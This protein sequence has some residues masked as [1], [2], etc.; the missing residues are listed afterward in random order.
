MKRT[1]VLAVAVA[2]CCTLVY[3]ATVHTKR[4][5]NYI[6]EGPGAYYELIAIV[7]EN[8]PLEVV[9]KSDQW[10]QV[11]VPDRK[12][13]WIA[14]NCLSEK[15]IAGAK[16]V[17]LENVWSSPKA[18]RAGVSAAIKGFGEKY[19]KSSAGVLDQV[20]NMERKSF[21]AADVAAFAQALQREPSANRGRL[22]LDKL[23]L[24]FGG[25]DP[26]LSEQKIGAG[27]AARI[28]S[29]GLVD[30]RKLLDY[31][32]L[33]AASIISS[34][35][36][37]DWDVTIYILNDP[38]INGFAVPGGYI[39]ITLGAIQHCGDEAELAAIIA[40]E[41]GHIIARHGLTE[42]TS[43]M[44]NIL[45]DEAFAE[46]EEETGP[47]TP[48]EEELDDLIDK[49]YESIVAR[50][51][52][53]YEVAADKMSSVFCANAGYDPF[54]LDRIAEKVARA[55]REEKSVFDPGYMTPDD[56]VK[57]YDAIKVFLREQFDRTT[58]GARMKDR[59]DESLKGR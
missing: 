52:L 24:A 57:R 1:L 25:F 48:D 15:P 21:S 31:V 40:H 19:G 26:G 39:F 55:P 56:A 2:F 7:P 35:G 11:R 12:N 45:A 44:V 36:L 20:L 54:G 38:R 51:L 27:I 37:F 9:E 8:T 53:G 10:V 18:S 3:G 13:G 4:K 43:R 46:L 30:D 47:K 49:T 17:S 28:A 5:N 50:R 23:G 58:P 42:M 41:I 34:S 29:R 6:R 33:I 22:Q 14:S 59:R 16:Q 32:N